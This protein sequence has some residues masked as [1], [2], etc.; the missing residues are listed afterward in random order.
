[1]DAEKSLDKVSL[2]VNL[3][4]IGIM[5]IGSTLGFLYFTALFFFTKQPI[6]GVFFLI[7]ASFSIYIFFG[8]YGKIEMNKKFITYKTFTSTL[9]NWL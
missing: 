9:P 4:L 2:S 8:A 1:M 3:S 5:T 6:G 7:L